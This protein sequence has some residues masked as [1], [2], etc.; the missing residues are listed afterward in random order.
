MHKYPSKKGERKKKE[1]KKRMQRAMKATGRIT[2]A[3][4]PVPV[5][6]YKHSQAH[7]VI[8]EKERKKW[9]HEA[10]EVSDQKSREGKGDGK[11][12]LPRFSFT[13]ESFDVPSARRLHHKAVVSYRRLVCCVR[14]QRRLQRT[15]ACSPAKV[16]SP[17]AS[18]EKWALKREGDCQCVQRHSVNA[19]LSCRCGSDGRNVGVCLFGHTGRR[20]KWIFGISTLSKGSCVCVESDYLGPC[21]CS[22]LV[23]TGTR[24]HE[25][26]MV[27]GVRERLRRR[28]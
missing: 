15:M 23:R 2:G 13:R 16:G 12:L 1:K 10:Q 19:L 5:H 9:Q 11:Q 14:R 8:G 25:R 4:D 6:R 27:T 24:G 18:S 17:L 28:R 3:H 21:L 22:S 26:R 20:E 7:E